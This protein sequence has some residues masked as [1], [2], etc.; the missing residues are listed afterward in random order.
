M[1]DVGFW[2]FG[3][4]SLLWNPGFNPVEKRLARLR[5]YSR[6]FCM[7][8]LHHR[9]TPESP[10]LVLALDERSGEHCDGMAFSAA[11]GESATVLRD[12]RERE[13]ISDAYLE[14]RVRIEFHDG[15]ETTAL[16]FI[17]DPEHEQY[18]GELP[19]E[20][21]V[22][23]IASARGGRGKNSEYL[24]RTSECLSLLGINDPL[25]DELADRVRA[26]GGD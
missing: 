21:Q 15:G 25:L 1:P 26:L 3:Y 9:G 16:A 4:G 8:S 22:G 6:S 14:R 23:I 7:R 19:I 18:C 5:G 11:P 12:L 24:Y 17:V 20:A 13:L 2:V 10:G